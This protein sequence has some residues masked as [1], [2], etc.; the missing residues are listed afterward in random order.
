MDSADNGRPPQAPQPVLG[1]TP[2]SWKQ[3][4]VAQQSSIHSLGLT[5]RGWAQRMEAGSRE[6]PWAELS[7]KQREAAIVLGWD[8]AS[9]GLQW[10][11]QPPP[12]PVQW[13]KPKPPPTL[14]VTALE[15]IQ[16]KTD[17][18]TLGLFSQPSYTSIG[19]PFR[20]ASEAVERRKIMPQSGVI[21][22]A[23]MNRARGASFTMKSPRRGKLKDAYF[24]KTHAGH[25]HTDDPALQKRRE[26]QQHASFIYSDRAHGTYGMTVNQL[27]TSPRFDRSGI[28]LRSGVPQPPIFAPTNPAKTTRS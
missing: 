20:T 27:K 5:P 19:D 17:F 26:I 21:H 24:G 23:L 7:E 14:R 8:E 12:D 11:N 18:K 3:M 1:V 15:A 10:G 6:K 4:S 13:V 16:C 22:D 25:N 2:R 9:W 28:M